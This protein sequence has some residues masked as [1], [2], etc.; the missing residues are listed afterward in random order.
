MFPGDENDPIDF[1]KIVGCLLDELQKLALR[2]GSFRVVGLRR[3]GKLN[4]L[5]GS[6]LRFDCYKVHGRTLRS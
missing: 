1:G 3:E 6:A 4:D 5:S 2:H